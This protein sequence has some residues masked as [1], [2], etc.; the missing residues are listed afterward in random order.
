MSIIIL[1]IPGTGL[2]LTSKIV[3]AEIC[4]DALRSVLQHRGQHWDLAQ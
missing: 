4:R 1:A 3:R 2:P